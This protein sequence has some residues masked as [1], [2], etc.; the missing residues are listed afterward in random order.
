[1]RVPI[2]SFLAILG[3]YA[4]A[5]RGGADM[6]PPPR[7]PVHHEAAILPGSGSAKSCA[8]DVDRHHRL[9]ARHGRSRHD[10]AAK[11]RQLE[12]YL[13]REVCAGRLSVIAAEA[14]LARNW[15]GA[16]RKYLGKP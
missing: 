11:K 1:M 10:M 8:P 5:A 2:A 4:V 14:E 15:Y 16:Y 7:T 13:Y 12:H 6:A 3:L 9:A